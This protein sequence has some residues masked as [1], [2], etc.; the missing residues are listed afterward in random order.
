MKRQPW[1]GNQPYG[2]FALEHLPPQ[3][4]IA[5]SK[6]NQAHFND[7]YQT[8]LTGSGVSLDNCRRIKAQLFRHPDG[9]G[10]SGFIT[11]TGQLLSLHV[12]AVSGQ[13]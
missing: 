1:S 6:K 10:I 5:I 8:F 13:Y 2:G 3:A 4:A 7:L 9:C 11:K 12:Y